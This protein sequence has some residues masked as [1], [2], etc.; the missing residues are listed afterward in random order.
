M[1]AAPPRPPLIAIVG[2]TAAG[3]SALA[4]QICRAVG[5]A[6]VSADSRQVYRGMDI[7]TAKPTKADR[8][9]IDHHLIDFR[10]LDQPY[11]LQEFLGDANAAIGQIRKSGQIPVVAGGTALYVQALLEGFAPGPADPELR[12]ELELEL[13]REGLA[14]LFDRLQRLDPAAAQAVDEKNPRRVVR[15][16]ERRLL[17]DRG[18]NGTRWPAHRAILLG[19]ADPPARR[20]ARIDARARAMLEAG[21]TDEVRGLLAAHGPAPVL[22]TT[23]G[24]R[25]C[26]DYLLGRCD[27]GTAEL[28]IRTATSR[29]SRRQMT[30][31]RNKMRIQWLDPDRPRLDQALSLL[32]PPG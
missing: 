6:V 4:V 30:Y 26:V 1:P 31:M 17:H 9:R 13:A 28:R 3:K 20:A 15:A 22:L 19:L 8:G 23:I 29:Y 27:L 32:R 16:V 21:L 5:G 10:P 2:P 12:K 7:G 24:Y 11:S 18:A 25:E 14:S